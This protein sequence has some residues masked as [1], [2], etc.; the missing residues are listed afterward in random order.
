MISSYTVEMSNEKHTLVVTFFMR[1]QK[2]CQ[3]AGRGPYER[4][5]GA[6]S[7]ASFVEWIG[8]HLGAGG[9]RHSQQGALSAGC[10]EPFDRFGFG[11][12]Q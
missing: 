1:E 2:S 5:C 8:K 4:S 12:V 11:C 10:H 3:D 9:Y 6:R 7:Q